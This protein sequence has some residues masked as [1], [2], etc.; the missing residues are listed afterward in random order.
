MYAIRSYYG[1]E[2]GLVVLQRFVVQTVDVLGN[3][4]QKALNLFDHTVAHLEIP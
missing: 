3:G 4:I 2:E 1:F